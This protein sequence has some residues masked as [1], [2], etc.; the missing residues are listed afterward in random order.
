MA[1]LWHVI[2]LHLKCIRNNSRGGLSI[3]GRFVRAT[4]ES[5]RSPAELPRSSRC[6]RQREEPQNPLCR[7][8]K[9][10]GL[11]L[12][13]TGWPSKGA[14]WKNDAGLKQIAALGDT[15]GLHL[16]RAINQETDMS[17]GGRAEE[18]E[19]E[20][21][22]VRQ[23]QHIITS[24]QPQTTNRI[25]ASYNL[26]FVLFPCFFLTLFYMFQMRYKAGA[27]PHNT[28]EERKGIDKQGMYV[29]FKL[30]L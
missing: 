24:V 11:N 18:T 25:R 21:P 17:E 14:G 28:Y 22:E 26:H 15:C 30:L 1:S 8:H 9:S 23:Q 2:F 4:A 3:L 16:N 7:A 19:G 5:L 20:K 10:Q 13:V 12:L 27:A 6:K 29:F